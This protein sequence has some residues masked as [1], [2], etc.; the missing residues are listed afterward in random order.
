MVQEQK[1]ARMLMS[2]YA[3][4]TTVTG[5]RCFKLIPSVLYC[6]EATTQTC[7]FQW[8]KGVNCFY[9][10]QGVIL[11]LQDECKVLEKPFLLKACISHYIII[12]KPSLIMP[13]IQETSD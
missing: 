9:Q 10:L 13:S 1:H 12:Y 2:R 6:S 5:F 8:A 11:I 3:K 7:F 4:Q